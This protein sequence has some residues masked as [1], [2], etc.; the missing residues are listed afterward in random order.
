MPFLK[1]LSVILFVLLI[2]MIGFSTYVCFVYLRPRRIVSEVTPEHFNLTPFEDVTFTTVD[3][4]ALKGW[5][6]PSTKKTDKVM[7]V[8]HGYPADK[9]NVLNVSTMFHEDYNLLLFDFRGL[10][11]SEGFFTTV[12]FNETKDLDAAVSFLK[13]KGMKKIGALG[14]SMGGAIIIMAENPDIYAIVADAPYAR[15]DI[16][17]DDVYENF[18]IFKRPFAYTTKLIAKF[19]FRMDIS[20]VSPVDSVKNL[21]VPLFLIHSKTDM[22]VD[23]KNSELLHKACPN[24][25]LWILPPARHGESYFLYPEEYKNNVLSFFKKHMGP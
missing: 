11:Q 13:D 8:C 12:G 15:L 18:F 10:G 1:E 4:I 25:E 22:Q 19:I 2:F 16:M 5:Y 6:I 7:I 23:I 20:K 9:G 24:S 21:R 14:F 3:G 17:L